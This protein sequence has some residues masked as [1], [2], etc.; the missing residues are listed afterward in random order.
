[1]LMY[2]AEILKA[3]E[4]KD[5]FITPFDAKKL[6]GASYD[7]ELGRE[8][9]VSNRDQKVLLGPDRT[10][11]LNLEAG[12]FALVLTKESMK[13]PLD[14]AG[15][16]G[17]RSTLARMGVILLH[18]MQIDPGFEGYL[19]FGL[20][21]ASPRKITLDYGDDICMIEFHKLAGKA[22]RPAPRNEDLIEGKI[23]EN[24][25]QFLR[26]METT[27]LS[28][29]SQDLRT[30]S[31]SVS[32]LTNQVSAFAAIQ[33]KFIIPGILAIIVGVVVAII[34]IVVKK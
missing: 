27:S 23:P 30:M 5:L 8:A 10:S 4:K 22:T 15:V 1:M 14:I 13:L 21:N 24:D 31:K 19:R 20:Y 32:E 18:G 7:L 12:D 3:M 9:L 28:S 34:T 2:D 11:G 17:M 6:K 16:I 33:N 26:T 25:R 29:V